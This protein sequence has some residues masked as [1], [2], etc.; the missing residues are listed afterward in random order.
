MFKSYKSPVLLLVFFHVTVIDGYYY[1]HI[2]S[3][4]Y[5]GIDHN[6]NLL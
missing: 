1:K 6:S 3:D 2:P 4:L 5:L